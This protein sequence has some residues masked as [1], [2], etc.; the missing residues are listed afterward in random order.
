MR[1]LN[2]NRKF[3]AIIAWNSFFHLKEDDQLLTFSLL[4]KHLSDDGIIMLTVGH[5]KGKITGRVNT[6]EVYHS[7]LSPEEYKELMEKYNLTII[8]FVLRDPECNNHT[9]L[10]AKKSS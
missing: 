5:E 8:D 1:Q 2:L 9:V 7:S 4:N 6:N 10:L 3:K